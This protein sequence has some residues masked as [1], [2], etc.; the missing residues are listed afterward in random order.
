MKSVKRPEMDYIIKIWLSR[1]FWSHL[2]LADLRSRYKRSFLGLGWCFVKPFGM[3]LLLSFVM[4]HI[5]HTPIDDSVLFIYS[6]LVIWEF[7]VLSVLTGSNAFVNAQLYIGQFKHPLAIYPLR[8]VLAAFIDMLFAFLG[9]IIFVFVRKPSNFGMAWMGL[10]PTFLL[11]FLTVLPV[12]TIAAFIGVRFRDFS[13]LVTLL[14][15][16][17]QLISPVFFQPEVFYKGN[18]GF[19]MDINPI[20]HL[21]ELFRAP[22]LRGEWASG[23]DLAFILL[24]AFS[25][26]LLACLV[27]IH[28]ERRVIFYL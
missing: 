26:W 20:Y 5:F 17:L 2:A 22:L 19:I 7:I 27:I 23:T 24:T 4:G 10:L 18:I 15:Q 9:L 8:S 12:V 13:Q 1:Y 3:T 11:L 21:M 16:A 6:G 28:Q 25:L 14:M